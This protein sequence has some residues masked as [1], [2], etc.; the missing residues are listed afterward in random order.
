MPLL[1][2][3]NL[4]HV[5]RESTAVLGARDEI[6]YVCV[7]GARG[8][9]VGVTLHHPHC[10]IDASPFAPPIAPKELD[11]SRAHHRKHGRCLFC[12]TVQGELGD[13]RRIVLEG[14]RFVA[15]VP[16]FARYPYEVYLAPKRHQA[17]MADWTAADADDLAAVLK[18]LLRKYDALFSKPFP[19]IMVCH[20]A[21]TDGT[22]HPEYHL[23]FEFY[24][25]LRTAQK[26]KY[27]AGCEAGAGNFIMDKLPEE[28]AAELR[29]VGP[30]TA[31]QVRLQDAGSSSQP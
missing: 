4:E 11:A 26:L 27:L 25:P 29:R 3:A 19:Y 20:Q 15:F 12:D 1:R 16:F 9:A 28:S 13:G 30:A 5:F 22:P 23:H 31:E 10:Q 17:T 24:P 18:G 14:E 7:G 21:P 8:G 6:Q 2:I